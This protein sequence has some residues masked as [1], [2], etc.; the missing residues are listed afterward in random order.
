MTETQVHFVLFLPKICNLNLIGN[1]KVR[2]VYKLTF[3][4]VKFMTHEKIKAFEG[5]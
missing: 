1:I 2:T 4:S 3:W 5:S